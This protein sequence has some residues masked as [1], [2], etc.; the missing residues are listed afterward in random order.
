MK[1]DVGN[2][3]YFEWINTNLPKG[4]KLGIDGQCFSVEAFTRREKYFGEKEI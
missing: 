2:P 4:T 1:I 3:Y